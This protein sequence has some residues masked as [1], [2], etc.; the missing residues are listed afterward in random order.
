MTT[1]ICTG[2]LI[3]RNPIEELFLL[4]NEETIKFFTDTQI[5]NIAEKKFSKEEFFQEFLP[6]L[7]KKI[8]E[9]FSFSEETDFLKSNIKAPIIVS[10][11]KSVK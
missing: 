11:L 7:D 8:Q 1:P 2:R 10:F 9:K 6:E 3:S 5:K 4:E